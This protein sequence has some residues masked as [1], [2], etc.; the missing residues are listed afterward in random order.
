MS[1]SVTDDDTAGVTV[2]AGDP[3]SVAEGGTATYQVSLD[4]QPTGNVVITVSS[5][6][7][8]VTPQPTSLTFTSDNW[9]TAQTVTVSAAHDGD[10]VDDAATISHVASGANESPVLRLPRWPCQLPMTTNTP[11]NRP[12]RRNPAACR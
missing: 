3:V 6:N 10:T 7:S 5:D 1:V 9:R 8:E 11:P 2:V 4:A 12:N